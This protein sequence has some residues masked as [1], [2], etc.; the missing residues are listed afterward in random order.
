MDL[1]QDDNSGPLTSSLGSG[2]EGSPSA[3]ESL[4]Q[5]LSAATLVTSAVCDGLETRLLRIECGFTRGFAGMQLIGNATEVCR[6][7]K[8]RA[9]AALEQLGLF[10]P[11]RRLVVSLT[12]ADVKKDGNHLDLP[13]ALS[14][15]LLLTDRE[16]KVE[17][18]R[19]LLAAELGLN[20]DL[21]PVRGIISMA[22]AAMGAGLDGVIVA[23]ENLEELAV[24]ASL[25]SGEGGTALKA[26]GFATLRDLLG[27]VFGQ[28]GAEPLVTPPS[29]GP[30]ATAVHGHN[31]DDMVLH[32][33]LEKAAIV[34]CAGM[35]SLLLRG[36]PGTGK[37]MLA[38]RLASIL[39]PL[40]REEH[41][42]ALRVYSGL[43]ER[44]PV[45]LLDGI[46]PFRAPHHQASAAAILG[47]PEVP[48]E[49]ALA[50]GGIL[51]LD[52]LPEFRRDILES[53]REPLETGEIRVSRSRRKAQWKCRLIVVAACNNCPC[54]WNGS[55]RRSCFCGATRIQAYMG[56]ISGPILDRIDLHVNMPEPTHDT[57]AI[58]LRLQSREDADQ[59]ARMRRTVQKAREMAQERNR[60]FGVVFNADLKARDLVQAS[61][62]S[63]E[64]FGAL[65]SARIPQTASSR[66]VLRCL[67]VARTLADIDGRPTLGEGDI[68]Q[69][70]HWQAEKAA[71]E[72]GEAIF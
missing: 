69:A 7:G 27:W 67:R 64:V 40:G 31:F 66:S 46:P 4:T 53:L 32:P 63:P 1:T 12:P 22:I 6:D 5:V 30:G 11:P 54:G 35:H 34:T 45:A 51:F 48:G 33:M 68:D 17:A 43:S 3:A 13:I 28:P 25:R 21:R 10:L 49:L 9:R 55:T 2:A 44:L 61:G 38:S 18:R 36:S 57:G 19:W 15:A 72:R 39:P 56:R 70:W 8:E 20:G 59:T 60:A 16:P 29:R 24:L 14:L 47:G 62:L 65:V 58:F 26:L 52:E 50:H 42:E 37:S 23:E 41:I 71:Q